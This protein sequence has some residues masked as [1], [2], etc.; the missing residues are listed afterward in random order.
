MHHKQLH[1]KLDQALKLSVYSKMQSN[2]S[3]HFPQRSDLFFLF[4][5]DL[6]DLVTSQAYEARNARHVT[7]I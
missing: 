4:S 1:N 6:T 3:G 2:R 5:S 7:S